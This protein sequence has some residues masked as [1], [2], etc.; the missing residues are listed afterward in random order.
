MKTKDVG[1]D[2]IAKPYITISSTLSV[3][4]YIIKTVNFA[5]TTILRFHPTGAR[6]RVNTPQF[7]EVAYRVH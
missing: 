1:S 3:F 2:C 6:N 5:F 4:K 7:K